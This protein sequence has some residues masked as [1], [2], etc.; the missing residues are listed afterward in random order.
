MLSIVYSMYINFFFINY[1]KKLKKDVYI[2]N[3]VAS[4]TNFAFLDLKCLI[5]YNWDLIHVVNL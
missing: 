2:L 1:P 4:S 5:D 3:S